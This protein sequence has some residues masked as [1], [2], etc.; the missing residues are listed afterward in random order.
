MLYLAVKVSTD[1]P[2]CTKRFSV[3]DDANC[4]TSTR[5]SL[6][7]YNVG[8]MTSLASF[9]SSPSPPVRST[10]WRCTATVFQLTRAA[11]LF[12]S[13]IDDRVAQPRG[14]N[15]FAPILR[16]NDGQTIHHQLAAIA[17]CFAL[18]RALQRI[19]LRFGFRRPGHVAQTLAV[20]PRIGQG[21]ATTI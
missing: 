14:R 11:G 8:C 21:I 5:P 7:I 3:E 18:H 12:E 6:A 13:M 9:M 4:C 16:P 10:S 15:V 17:C 2:R 20:R 19:D 1:C